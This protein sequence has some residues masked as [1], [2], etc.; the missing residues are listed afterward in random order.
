MAINFSEIDQQAAALRKAHAVL[1]LVT[2]S[3]PVTTEN[4]DCV[5][6][7]SAALGIVHDVIEALDNTVNHHLH[8]QHSG[9][10]N[11]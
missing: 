8:A 3:L 1:S 7:I 9:S 11:A 2:D 10:E 6:A 5:W 4:E